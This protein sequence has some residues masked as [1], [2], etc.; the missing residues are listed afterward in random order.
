M[1]ILSACPCLTGFSCVAAGE[2]LGPARGE[3]PWG[4]CTKGGPKKRVLVIFISISSIFSVPTFNTSTVFNHHSDLPTHSPSR[5]ESLAWCRAEPTGWY[6]PS[7]LRS[8][9][10]NWNPILYM[11][12]FIFYTSSTLSYA[13]III[14]IY[15]WGGQFIGTIQICL[16]VTLSF[17]K[18]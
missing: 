2:V 17:K 18:L 5:C 11:I 6:E 1:T 10:F 16:K 12:Q 15:R 3:R 13:L 7:L 4:A 9:Q 8:L 14:C